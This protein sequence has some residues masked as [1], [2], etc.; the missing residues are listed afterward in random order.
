MNLLVCYSSKYGG[1]YNAFKSIRKILTENFN[2]IEF[3]DVNKEFKNKRYRRLLNQLLGQLGKFIG[4]EYVRLISLG[5]AKKIN[6]HNADVVIMFKI[7]DVFS[8]EDLIRL[9]EEKR[10]IVRLS[11]AY[12]LNGQ[13]SYLEIKQ[14]NANRLRSKYFAKLN[15][16]FIVPS[17]YTKECVRKIGCESIYIPTPVFRSKHICNSHKNI[18]FGAKDLLKDKR[19]GLDSFLVF[20]SHLTKPFSFKL[21][22]ISKDQ[23]EK[24]YRSGEI[25]HEFYCLGNLSKNDFEEQ[26]H[27][28]GDTYLH[29]PHYENGS[30]QLKEFMLNG[31]KVIVRNGYGIS[32]N[33]IDGING[34][35]FNS[36]IDLK[37]LAEDFQNKLMKLPDTIS[38]LEIN[39]NIFKSDSKISE[40]WVQTITTE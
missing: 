28:L 5:F 34:Y 4:I 30:Q 32:D 17:K 13:K 3:L 35:K 39:E 26:I 25:R 23:F 19:K 6:L 29:M 21:L 1:A 11:D 40:K 38:I 10:Y 14:L 31:Y 24:V 27:Q 15:F 8:L 9:K 12:F 37:E 36:N 33:I 7:D 18:V 20:L 22:G 2:E 16:K